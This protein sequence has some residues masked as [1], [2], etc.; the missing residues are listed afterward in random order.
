MWLS[1]ISVRRPLLAVVLSALLCV[2]GLVALSKL[3]VREM[4]DVQSPSISINTRYEGAAPAVM[5]SQITK[6]IED[7]LSG[8]SGI[9]NITSVTRKGKS[10][11][12]VEFKLGWNMLEGASDVRDAVARVRSRLPEEADDPVVSKDN[13]MG[14]V[15][16]W[17]NFSS[18]QMDR[19]AMTDYAQRVLV[20]PLSLV[21]GV[22][23]V[24]LAGHLRQ[25]M[26]VR[27]NTAAMKA[28][29]LSI[30]SLQSA[31]KAENMALPA[32]EL[33]NNSMTLSVQ[34]ARLYQTAAD[35]A[36]L[37]VSRQQT[38]RGDW[39]TIY[40]GDIAEVEVA[41]KNEESSYQRNG[42]ASLGIG[43]IAQS[44]ANPLAVAQGVKAQVAKMQRFLPAGAVL[45]VDYDATVF[46]S[47]AIDEVYGTLAV[48]AVLVVAVL[49]LFL[50]QGRTTL[51]PAI[52]VPVSLISAFIGAWYLG[53]SINL[54]T[55]LALILAI[56]LVVD[57]AI[58]VVENI[59]HHLQQGQPPLLAAWHGTREV[60]FAVVATTAV[61]VMVFVPIAFMEGMVGKLFTEFAILLSVAVIF[62]SVIALTLTPAMAAWLMRAHS[63]PSRLSAGFE[64]LMTR[65][66]A[67]YRRMLT[68]CLRHS[69]SGVV[70]LLA[71]LL[72]MAW[73]GQ[74]IPASLTPNE[75][76]GVI[77]VFVKGAEGTSIE[78]MKRNMQRVEA[79]I[80][81][82]L[83]QGVVQALSFSTPAFGRGGDQ[84]GMVI[85]Q[86]TDWAQREV[87]ASDYTRRLNQL[88]GNIPDVMIRAFPPGFRGGS[89]APV[90]FVLQGN[91]YAEL[92]AQGQRLQAHAR[93]SGLML[94][95]DLD[96]AEATPELLAQIDQ[97]LAAQLGVNTQ[98]IARALQVL[99]GGVSQTTYVDR[100]EEYDVYLRAD[101]AQFTGSQ[102]LA[103]IYVNTASGE[104]VSLATLVRLTPVASANRLNH[105]Q[106]QKAIT[107]T[108]DVHPDSTLG[109]ALDVLDAWADSELP[110]GMSVDYAGESKDY[111]ENQGEMVLIFSLSLLVVYLVLVAQFES[112]LTPAVV[113]VTVPLGILGALLGLWL[114]GQQL[115]LYSQIGLIMLIGMVTKNGILIVEFINQLRSGGAAFDEAILQGAVRR[116]R[117]ILMTALTAIIGAVPLMLSQGAGFE[118]RMAVGTVI[119]FGLSLATVITLGLVPMIYHLLARRAGLTGATAAAVTAAL[120]RQAPPSPP[121]D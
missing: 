51:I 44:T 80:M 5:E 64:R 32:G 109:A 71:C 41:A 47:Q 42:Q 92:L 95:P 3:G 9:K 56:G 84:T 66:E 46:I 17:L 104:S 87:S 14:N 72:A 90:Q 28:R 76:R 73:L 20:D 49:Y 60:G 2:F 30:D 1:D 79:V 75:D 15:T 77:Y 31:L 7:Q 88:L 50:G 6:P 23:E 70:L 119:F 108:A 39:E 27:L 52:T 48:S 91:D 21:D 121:F 105:F 93:A 102:D 81:P 24:A 96:Y 59:H 40:L 38:P 11:I 85:I 69:R 94:A 78:R 106:R 58:V 103:R 22:S 12:T 107:L 74:R 98:T 45:E 18:T 65:T 26:Y 53:F 4:P 57:D 116:L 55:L 99:L 37:P 54:I 29:G 118:S 112:L 43:I 8:I 100:G 61:L 113:M 68:R 33:R 10:G 110:A 89:N 101:Q 16:V 83:G 120:S 86:L 111:R 13:G 62:S 19:T 36:R 97:P 63:T 67:A 115:S 25:V 34:V 82:E 114:T 117:P 35:F